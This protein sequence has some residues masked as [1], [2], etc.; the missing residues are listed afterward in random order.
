[1]MLSKVSNW[2]RA[3]AAPSEQIAVATLVGVAPVVDVT[4]EPLRHIP[5][6][7][8]VT[9]P[10]SGSVYINHALSN[11]LGVE[12][13]ILSNRYFPEDQLYLDAI[14]EFAR[15]GR[16]VSAHINASAVNLQILNAFVPRWIVHFRDPR[17][18]LLSWVH[19]QIGLAKDKSR[20]RLLLHVTPAPPAGFEGWALE[21]SIDWHIDH[22]LPSVNQWM[23]EWLA[24][25]DRLPNNMLLTEFSSLKQDERAYF[26]RVLS[27]LGIDPSRFKHLPPERDAKV[28]FRTGQ[29]DEWRHALTPDQLRRVNA[30]LPSALIERFGWPIS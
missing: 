2:F 8:M 30:S 11:G 3:G 1:M 29:V 10:K 9:I 24:V 17:S 21:R 25:A 18:V 13:L 19:H 27:F 26:H 7:L 23:L 20:S 22:F 4:P 15:G 28:H 6:I 12:N 5:S 14:D 16:I